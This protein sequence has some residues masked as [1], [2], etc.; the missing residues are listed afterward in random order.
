MRA[1]QRAT[2]F[3]SAIAL[4]GAVAAAFIAAL[5]RPVEA[6]VDNPPFPTMPIDWAEAFIRAAEDNLEYL[7]GEVV[8]KFRDGTSLAGQQQALDA[9]RSRPPVSNLQPLGDAF[10]LRDV[11]EWNAQILSA[12]LSSQPEVEY[13][14]P[15]YLYRLSFTPNDPGFAARQWNLTALDLPTAWDIND[16]AAN[17]TVAVVDSGVTTVN[18]TFGAVTWEGTRFQTFAVP[19]SVSPEM[20]SSRFASPR[21]FVG[22]G[23]TTVLD[24]VGH[25]SHVAGT[26]AQETNNNLAEAGIAY[27]ARIMPLKACFGY[28]E[29]Q[30]SMSANGR[31]GF[32]PQGAGGC[33]SASVAAGIRYAADNG[34]QVINLSLGGPIPATVLRDAIT[35]AVGRG[36]FVAIAMGNDFEAGNPTTYPAAYAQSIDGAM[37]VG[38]VGRSLRRSYFSNTGAHIEIAAPGGDIRDGGASGVVWQMTIFPPDSDTRTVI[39]PRFDRYASVGNQGT[40]MA[41]PHIAGVAALIISQ[42]VRNPAA[43]EALIKRTARPLGTSDASRPGWNNDF[44]YGL[45]QPRPALR[46]FGIAK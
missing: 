22:G 25:G 35:Y 21:D 44:G 8:V 39:F 27:R 26:I 32:T 9:I 20:S 14:E 15:N 36:A 7:P 33:D 17:V 30:F 29:L 18:Q 4:A 24:L 10:L 34:A 38:S 43:V 46:G 31:P 19:F 11:A 5:G 6:Q 12:Q 13:A 42:G 28:W 16:G 23:D 3:P 1:S 2:L 41:S 45:I 37:A 40:S